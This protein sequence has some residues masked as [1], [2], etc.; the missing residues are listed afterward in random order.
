MNISFKLVS[1]IWC[2]SCIIMRPRYNEI[3]KNNNISILELDFDD[4]EEEV[5]KLNIGNT[6]PALIIYKDNQE[7]FRITGE[8]S[9]K[10][11]DGIFH[12]KGIY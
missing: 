1:A 12:E 8:K 7:Y 11:L 9:K 5:N 2:P 6:L 10:E 4:D 3:S